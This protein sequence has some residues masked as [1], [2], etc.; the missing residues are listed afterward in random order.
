MKG[1]CVPARVALFLSVSRCSVLLS[2]NFRPNHNSQDAST[3]LSG[4]KS[5]FRSGLV[6]LR[7]I[8]GPIGSNCLVRCASRRRAVVGAG[9]RGGGCR[10]G[11]SRISDTVSRRRQRRGSTGSPPSSASPSSPSPQPWFPTTPRHAA[12]RRQALGEGLWS[13]S[14]VSR[15]EGARVEE[16]VRAVRGI[17]FPARAG[18]RAGPSLQLGLPPC[19]AAGHGVR[20]CG[21]GAVRRGLDPPSVLPLCVPGV[22][23]PRRPSRRGSGAPSAPLPVRAVALPTA[24]PPGSPSSSRSLTSSRNFFGCRL[25]TGSAQ[26]YFYSPR[27]EDSSTFP[28]VALQAADWG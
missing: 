16:E 23:R 12:R 27:V 6:R 7:T 19:V 3:F 8:C 24:R 26:C 11:A 25:R 13:V 5:S 14:A 17:V 22:P 2:L 20:R 4:Q 28:S 10:G 1:I 9:R 21:P 15:A 18:Q